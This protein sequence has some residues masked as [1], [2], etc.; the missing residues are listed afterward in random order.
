M[1]LSDFYIHHPK[2]SPVVNA[3]KLKRIYSY[4]AGTGRVLVKHHYPLWFKAKFVVLPLVGTVVSL[5]SF[6]H[7]Q[8]RVRWNRCRGQRYGLMARE[9]IAA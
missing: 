7:A 5:A 8:A 4:G 6:N 3:A 1:Y 9:D 2:A